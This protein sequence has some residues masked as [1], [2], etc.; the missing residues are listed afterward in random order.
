MLTF[1]PKEFKGAKVYQNMG[2]GTKKN[3]AKPKSEPE[4][5]NSGSYQPSEWA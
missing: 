5:T 2:T 1:P 3:I 4:F